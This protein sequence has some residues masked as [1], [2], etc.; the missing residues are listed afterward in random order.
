[1]T[2][3]PKAHFDRSKA[4]RRA[5]RGAITKFTKEVD[6]LLSETTILEDIHTRLR[7]IFRQLEAKA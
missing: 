6:E 4:M 2:E 1:M 7:V 5:H 3:D